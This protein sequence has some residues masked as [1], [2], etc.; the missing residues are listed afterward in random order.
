M[1]TVPASPAASTFTQRSPKFFRTLNRVV[2]IMG[3]LLLCLAAVTNF[4]VAGSGGDDPSKKSEEPKREGDRQGLPSASVL[5]RTK[6]DPLAERVRRN[7]TGRNA[8]GEGS[9][10]SAATYAFSTATGAALEDMSTGTTQLTGS[11]NDDDSSTLTNIGFD[12]WFDGVRYTQFAS[13]VNGWVELGAVPTSGSPWV[14]ENLPTSTDAPKIAPYWDDL[15]TGTNGKVHRKLF[16]TAPNRKLVI[17]WQNMQITRGAGCGNTGAGVFQ[18]WLFES[19]PTAAGGTVEFVYGAGLTTNTGADGGYSIGMATADSFASITAVNNTVD[20]ASHNST[21]FD[22]IA[23][24]R[25]YLFTPNN[26]PTAPTNLSFT[27]VTAAGMTLNWTDAPDEKGYAIYYS[28]DGTNY[29]SFGVAAANATSFAATGLAPGSTHFWRV[30]SVSEGAFSATALS[31]SQ[32]TTAAATYF[33]TGLAAGAEFNTGSNWNTAAD[34]TGST[35]SSAQTTDVM[36]I[37]GAGT[38][39]GAA[40]VITVNASVSVG[41]LRITN[42]TQVTLRAST[43]T[44]RTVTVTGGGGDEFDVQAGSTLLMN[45]ATQAAAIAFNTGV[46]MTGNIAGTL[47]LGGSANNLV[48]TT[49]GTGTVV[50]VA[51]TGIVNLT[52]TTNALVGSAA[53][54][55]IANGANINSSG[56]TTGA[57]PVPLATW[58]AT[59]NLTISGLTSSTTAPTNNIQSFGNLTYNCPAA[60]GT[61]SFFTTSTTAAIQGTL[62]IQATNTGRF[63]ALTTGTLSVGNL[64]VNNGTFEAASGN[65]TLNVTGAVSQSGGVIDVTSGAAAITATMRVGGNFNE[66]AGNLRVSGASTANSLEFNGSAAQNFTLATAVTGA[67]NV[68]VNNTA[69]VNLTGALAINANAGVTISKGNITGSGTISYSATNTR[70]V[71]NSTTTAQTMSAVEYPASGPVNLTINNTNAAPNNTVTMG[72]SRSMFGSSVLTLTSGILVN[73]SNV[74]TIVNTGVGAISGG[75]A[76]SYVAGALAR[77][78]PPNLTGTLTYTLPIGKGTYNPFELANPTT[79]ASGA[80][81]VQ[82]EVFD[83]NAGGTPGANMGTLNTDRYWAAS[84]AAGGSNFTNSFVRLTDASASTS[85]AIASSSSLTGTYDIVGGTSPTVVAGTSVTSVAPAATTIPGFFVLGTKAVGMTYVSSTTTQAV[86]TPVIAG[87]TD[88]QVIGIQVVTTGN[89]SPINATSFSVNTNGTTAPGTDITNAK[90]WYT[91]T[92]ST[93][94][95]TTQFGATNPAPAG[96][97][98]LTGSQALAEGTN[99]FWLTYDIPANATTNNVVDAACT[100]LTVV[101]PQTPTV[102]APA[103]SRTIKAALSGTY[104]IGASQTLPNY[105]KLTDAIADLNAFGVSGP[106]VFQL[107]ADYNSATETYP[108]TINAVTGGSAINT[109]TIRPAAGVTTSITGTSAT[110]LLKLNGA[111]FIIVDGSNSGGTDRSLTINNTATNNNRAGIWLAS[112]GTGQGATFNTI[113]NTNI[114]GG[115]TTN[116]SAGIAITGATV[117]ASGADNDNNTITNNRITRAFNAI[118]VAGTANVSAGGV[119]NL[120]VS[121]NLLGP[122]T[123]VS[124]NQ[125]GGAGVILN[126]AVAPSVTGNAIRNIINAA[127][128]AIPAGILLNTGVTNAVI[129]QNTISDVTANGSQAAASGVYVGNTSSGANVS[130]T[131][132]ANI[133]AT[134]ITS[135]A[136][137]GVLI[138]GSDAVVDQVTI[139]N[140]SDPTAGGNNTSAYGIFINNSGAQV[141]RTAITGIVN[142][143]AAGY[144]AAGI[145]VN[146]LAGPGTVKLVNNTVSDIQSY[147]DPSAQFQFQPVGIFVENTTGIDIH[148]N[149]VYLS[150]SHPGL[151]SATKQT[152]LYV[153]NNVTNLNVRNNI[154]ADTYDNSSSSTELSYAIFSNAPASAF[155][156]LNYNDYFCTGPIGF[157]GGGDQADLAAWRIATGQDAQ[158]ISADPLF[159]SATN[160]QPQPGSPVLNAGTPVVGIVEDYTGGTRNV[161]NPSVGA[162]EVGADSSGPVISYPPLAQTPDT[163][164][165]PFG[166]VTITD[167]SGVNVAPGTKPR[168]Y[169]KRSTD[170]NSFGDNTSASPGWKYAEANGTTSPFDFTIDYSLL[171]GGTG[172][173]AQQDV[174]YFVV[175]QDLSPT[176]YLSIDSGTFAAPPTSVALASAAFPIGGTINSY[177]IFLPLQGTINICDGGVFP[178]LKSFFDAVNAGVVTGNLV[179]NIAGDC[180]EAPDT[181]ATLHQWTESP[182]GSNYTMRIV[183][184]GGVPRAINGA[185]FPTLPFID[186]DGADRVTI[187]GLNTGGNALTIVSTTVSNGD[188][189]STLRFEGDA[190]NNVV[191]NCTILGSNVGGNAGTIM[192]GQGVTSGN[193]NNTISY[194]NIG[195]AGSNLP[196][197]AIFAYGVPGGAASANSGVI[198]DHNNI[199]DFFDPNNISVGIYITDGNDQ[200]TVSNNRLYQSA[201]RTDNFGF[202]Y[203]GITIS[204]VTA[205]F[206]TYSVTGNTIGF[207]NAAGTGVTSVSGFANTV[208]PINIPQVDNSVPTSVQ[209]NVIGGIAQTTTQTSNN[210]IDVPFIGIALGATDGRFNVGNVT[211]NIIG[212]QTGTGNITITV[213]NSTGFAP[214]LGIYDFSLNATA[215]NISN[216]QIGGVTVNGTTTSTGFTGIRV[217]SPDVATIANNIIGGT[218]A[219]SISIAGSSAQVIGIQADNTQEIITGNT[220][221]NLQHTG[222]NTN[223]FSSAAVIGINAQGNAVNETVSNN[224]IYGLSET[225]AAA[226]QVTGIMY[227]GPSSGTNTISGN[228]IHSFT[229]SGTAATLNGMVVLGGPS[230]YSNNMIRLGVDSAGNSITTALKINGISVNSVSSD[231]YN[232]YSNSIYI[233][234]TGVGATASN[235]FALDFATTNNTRV[236]RNNIFANFRSN[237]TTGGKHYALTI[238]GTGTNPT[239]LTINN[240]LYFASG[241]GG[242]MGLYGG[243]D[244]TTIAAWK[245]ATGQDAASNQADPLFKV[246][247]GTTATLDLHIPFTSPANAAGSVV[248]AVTND[249][250]SDPRPGTAPDIGADE[251]VNGSA[252]AVPAGTYYNAAFTTGDNLAGDVTV[253]NSLTLNG[254][255]NTG[256]FTLNLGC[257]ASV[258]GA[259]AGNFVNGTLL[260]NYCGTGPFTYPVG[261]ASGYSPVDVNVTAIGGAGNDSLSVRAVPGYYGQNGE[262]PALSNQSLQRYWDMNKTG[263][264][265]ADIKWNFQPGDVVGGGTNYRIIRISGTTATSFINAGD[266]PA[267]PVASPCVNVAGNYFFMG[268]VSNFSKWTAGQQLAPTAT[269]AKIGGRILDANGHPIANARVVLSGGNLAQPT[270]VQT[271]PFGY[272]L[273]NDVEVGRL[274]VVTVQSGRH[275]FTD[276]SRAIEVSADVTNADF[277]A[278]P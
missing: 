272:Y 205:P 140:I 41:V 31:G 105:T 219:N 5:T 43:T 125:L 160:L 131:S 22:N 271:G 77:N 99:Y 13:N 154:F 123:I 228:L 265:T 197:K 191:T 257:G 104:T 83:A 106:V 54:L 90:I 262:T 209:G 202:L 247:N 101:S 57:P 55:S 243:S 214:S 242:V 39:A 164:N 52:S 17:E 149:S 80:I 274:Y 254:V 42:N 112:L 73:G 40:A 93:F 75:S 188:N 29:S 61:M 166:N 266:C 79:G 241:T 224:T 252:G 177:H 50:T 21:Q 23:S 255:V 184:F 107:A 152:G 19:A 143:A 171:S 121:N 25:A 12:F 3:I 26:P 49:G 162:Y 9:L 134:D 231:S 59:S 269:G 158:S 240:N 230:T 172:V 268:G 193:D 46:G 221:R 246:P 114:I 253:T 235:T 4:P 187:D 277:V 82:A 74:L 156:T 248:A 256:A 146:T 206:G 136:A 35:R 126:N 100:S 119:D 18:L 76:T 53:T 34:G 56:A 81:L 218:T 122:D 195:P 226:V 181:T 178:T 267:N 127:T 16:G 133:T 273:F 220:I 223:Q 213:N 276:P 153:A 32:A 11:N 69:G 78:L 207:A 141:T 68:R 263:S 84:L 186:L 1:T 138:F 58:G 161:T 97:F 196:G 118:L 229:G 72:F 51:S 20:Y 128:S 88:Q 232:F 165:R 71:Y 102:T 237:T 175:A 261:T 47:T 44:T 212:G 155:T 270:M 167:V 176:P 98:D 278:E 145:Y 151:V 7:A 45:N 189:T 36:I 216:N 89:T 91:G 96:S 148:F 200:W 27:G 62:T 92:S 173:I 33:W 194:N 222:A 244:R 264:I 24:G 120:V 110:A 198:I 225:A 150:G 132:I 251:I 182:A 217:N 10:I 48:T 190:T 203:S 227:G 157:I 130:L 144:R 211:G 234:G 37:D 233:G 208:R 60:T 85:S 249:F 245:T 180:N 67:L 183:P 64:T 163:T 86:T 236:L 65:G 15:C 103:G 239:G 28:P 215:T 169:Y 135:S 8:D 113:K 142:G 38:T 63:R 14:N 111:D 199:Y 109:V 159:N 174:Q 275:T 192:I 170:P 108:M 250:D 87:S 185:A 95:T 259:G 168:V 115:S 129:A 2:V 139:A 137:V 204:P 210:T 124:G 258:T 6:A 238:G 66:S 94:A 201:P 117:S 70:L 147:S 116:T 260:K 30:Y 179:V